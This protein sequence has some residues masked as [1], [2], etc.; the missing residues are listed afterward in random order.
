MFIM[1]DEWSDKILEYSTAKYAGVLYSTMQRWEQKAGKF[2]H[3]PTHL[4]VQCYKNTLWYIPIWSLD[5]DK[6]AR[7][8]FQSLL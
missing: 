2:L 3:N 5:L 1:K 7:T 4:C 8:V 6:T